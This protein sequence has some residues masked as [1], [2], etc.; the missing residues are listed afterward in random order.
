MAAVATFESFQHELSRLVDKFDRD[1]P[2]FVASTY[3]EATLRNEF[4]D[5]FFRA[6]GWD[7]GNINGLIHTEREV[8]IEV[9]T[10]T[11]GR[12]TRADYVF[13]ISRVERFTCEAKKPAEALNDRHIYQAK[14]DA[15]ARSVP[16]AIQVT[17]TIHKIN[18]PNHISPLTPQLEF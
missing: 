2:Q 6:L 4:L 17:S 15:F 5:P 3:N 12:Q 14:R 9:Q 13:R 1:Y 7:V 11:S 10:A 18:S 16:F 8:D